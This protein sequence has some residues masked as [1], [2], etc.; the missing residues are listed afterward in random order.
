VTCAHWMRHRNGALTC[1]TPCVHRWRRATRSHLHR[2]IREHA[3]PVASRAARACRGGKRS[4]AVCIALAG[5]LGGLVP[6]CS[7][8]LTKTSQADPAG[9]MFHLLVSLPG[10]HLEDQKCQRHPIPR[11]CPLIRRHLPLGSAGRQRSQCTPAVRIF[12]NL[13]RA[14]WLAG[15][16]H[17]PVVLQRVYKLPNHGPSTLP[18]RRANRQDRRPGLRPDNDTPTV[19]ARKPAPI[20]SRGWRM[21]TRIRDINYFVLDHP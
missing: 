17:R 4:I 20:K 10:A 12:L 21:R 19:S 5:R 13:A 3:H 1:S 18:L 7:S 8:S 2:T 6:A 16:L 14:F 9:Q 11:R 15:E